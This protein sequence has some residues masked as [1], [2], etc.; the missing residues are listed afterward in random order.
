MTT[1]ETQTESTLVNM[2]HGVSE[3]NSLR[4]SD[5][6][7]MFFCSTI[8]CT[9]IALFVDKDN[10]NKCQHHINFGDECRIADIRLNEDDN[11]TYMNLIPGST[12]YTFTAEF[13]ENYRLYTMPSYIS[14]LAL[15][16]KMRSAFSHESRALEKFKEQ[17]VKTTVDWDGGCREGKQEFLEALGLEYP[18]HKVTVTITF[19]CSD[20]PSN[21]STY[22]IEYA[23]SNL[24]DDATDIYTDIDWE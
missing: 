13:W 14:K 17:V 21:V 10:A 19:E 8:N 22:D 6:S 16:V 24:V 3:E 2:L 1:V 15:A 9:E 7:Y 11:I 4:K 12:R 20:D 23:V 18:R 5:M